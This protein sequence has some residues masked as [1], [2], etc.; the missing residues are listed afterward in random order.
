MGIPMGDAREVFGRDKLNAGFPGLSSLFCLKASAPP[1]ERVLPPLRPAERLPRIDGGRSS[2]G[3]GGGGGGHATS[4]AAK[5]VV[6]FCEDVPAFR[7]APS[8]KEIEKLWERCVA[9][10]FSDPD[11]A[12]QGSRAELPEAAAEE[13]AESLH[14]QLLAGCAGNW[15]LQVRALRLIAHLFGMGA[16]GRSV[17]SRAMTKAGGLV[18]YLV[19]EVPECADDASRLMLIWQLAQVLPAGQEVR[20]ADDGGLLHFTAIPAGSCS[21]R[22]VAVESEERAVPT[23]TPTPSVLATSSTKEDQRSALDSVDLLCLTSDST[24]PCR[25]SA[26]QCAGGTAAPIEANGSS[27]LLA[28]LAEAFSF[29]QVVGTSKLPTLDRSCLAEVAGSSE[30]FC[31]ATP[32]SSRPTE[33]FF[34]GGGDGLSENT[35]LDN[36]FSFWK[37]E[38][39]VVPLLEDGWTLTQP[40]RPDPFAFMSEQLGLSQKVG[41]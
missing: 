14:E 18:K 26:A 17:A 15:H 22:R 10:A 36:M 16:A 2:G 30:E 23:P 20:V 13:V 5:L 1:A 3:R 33:Q 8:G 27:E 31:L 24:E 38:V 40:A 25:T 37:R 12:S 34:I 7:V 6:E 4:V 41:I 35:D 21:D 11:V 39:P 9:T 28:M 32:R 19:A 29:V